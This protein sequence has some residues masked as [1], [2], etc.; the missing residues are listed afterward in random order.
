L[1]IFVSVFHR[2]LDFKDGAGSLS[3][4]LFLWLLF[5]KCFY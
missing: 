3:W 1:P 4:P 2:I 5:L